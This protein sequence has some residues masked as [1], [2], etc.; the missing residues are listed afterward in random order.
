MP[1]GLCDFQC[2]AKVRDLDIILGAAGA[3]GLEEDP[4]KEDKE[5][6]SVD[7]LKAWC[8]LKARPDVHSK[9]LSGG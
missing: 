5:G 1:I 7:K 3:G 2:V 9:G 8:W 4:G 6:D